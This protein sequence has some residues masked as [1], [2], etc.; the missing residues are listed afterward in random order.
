M[1]NTQRN[2]D[3]IYLTQ[4]ELAAEVGTTRE[5]VARCLAGLQTAGVI[6]LGRGRVTMLNREKLSQ[7]A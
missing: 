5:V 6:R 4:A 1:D 2:G 3:L 7:V